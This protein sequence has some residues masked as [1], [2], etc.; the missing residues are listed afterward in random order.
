M[1]AAGGG[2]T[3][4]RAATAAFFAAVALVLLAAEP[5]E[6]AFTLGFAAAVVVAA[7]VAAVVAAIA[8]RV[9]N[10]NFLLDALAN[11]TAAG[12]GFAAGD[13]HLNSAGALNRNLVRHAHGVVASHAFRHAASAGHRAADL[14]RLAAVGRAADG[15]RNLFAH[16]LAAGHA[17]LFALNAR[18]PQHFLETIFGHSH[19]H[20]QQQSFFFFFL[21]QS[22]S[23]RP[24]LAGSHTHS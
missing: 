6:E 3:A 15:A 5:L 7:I 12:H 13:A 2:R 8:A 22:R 14:L 19:E 10:R 11:H 1:A 4:A 21:P 18:A 20:S 24:G 16:L 17:A 23:K 9:A